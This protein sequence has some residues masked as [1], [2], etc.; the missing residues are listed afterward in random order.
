MSLTISSPSN[1]VKINYTPRK[2]LYLCGFDKQK[3]LHFAFYMMGACGEEEGYVG[4]HKFEKVRILDTKFFEKVATVLKNIP[5]YDWDWASFRDTVL[6]PNKEHICKYCNI[7]DE[8]IWDRFVED[9][10][11][12]L[13]HWFDTDF[14]IDEDDGSVSTYRNPNRNSVFTHLDCEY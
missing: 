3:N 6:V 1:T 7:T 14:E 8:R 4:S 9:G 2:K 12:F 13:N 5:H 11:V 10:F